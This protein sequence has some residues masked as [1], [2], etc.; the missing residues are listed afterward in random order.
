MDLLQRVI[1]YT[2]NE[3]GEFVDVRQMLRAISTSINFKKSL[4]DHT[5]Y[6][7]MSKGKVA[8]TLGRGI[9]E[10]LVRIASIGAMECTSRTEESQSGNTPYT[11]HMQVQNKLAR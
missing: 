6:L 4:D 11:D 8:R 7:G 2:M 3:S 5:T 10:K 1:H 9:R